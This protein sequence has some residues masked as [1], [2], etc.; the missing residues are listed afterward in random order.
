MSNEAKVGLLVILVLAI[1]VTTFIVVANVQLTGETSTY[2]TY[3]AYIGGLDEG[4]VVRF[5]GR[6]AGIIETVRPWSEDMTKSEV[7]FRIRAEIP[8]TQD[9]VATIASLSALGQNYLE[10]LPG[11]I[12][13]PR[14]EP[15]GVVPS[16]EALTFADLTRKVSDVADSAVDLMTRV[17]GKMSVVVDNMLDLMA[18]LQELTGEENQ[19]NVARMLEN[20][21]ALAEELRPKIDEITTQLSDTL[22]EVKALAED[23]RSVAQHADTTI[24]N[25]NRT[26]EETREPI[27]SSLAELE[28]TL[29]DARLVMG[30]AR[31]LVLANEDDIV[32]IMTNLR[33]ASK[34]ISELASDLRQRPWTLLR[35]RPRADRQVPPVADSGAPSR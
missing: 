30:D 17:D 10:V 5:G 2:R 11:T 18:N 8:V 28:G 1:F 23:S 31:A 4:N 25:A 3:F 12:D 15:G 16:A 21:N 26:V 32:E 22:D 6:K 13:S 33:R 29:R 24:V 34:E 20:T 19:R 9:S 7:V 27:K 35:S 14:I